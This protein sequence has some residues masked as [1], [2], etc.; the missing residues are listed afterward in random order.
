[1]K[2]KISEYHEI[3][4]LKR[5]EVSKYLKNNMDIIVNNI[6]SMMVKKNITQERLADAIN[7]DQGHLNY[8][9][10]SRK[11]IT[12]NVL[13]RIAYAFDVPLYEMVK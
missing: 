10:K 13:S 5:D 9:L 11:G 4:S 8:I 7:S 2:K 12:V 1:M 6:I 3:K